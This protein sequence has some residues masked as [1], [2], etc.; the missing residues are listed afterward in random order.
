M[1]RQGRLRGLGEA[2]EVGQDVRAAVTQLVVELAARAELQQV[3]VQPPPGQ[4]ARGVHA[5]LRVAGIEEAVEPGVELGEEVTA[6]LD[7]GAA[8]DQGRR[9]SSFSRR[10][11]ARS[12]AT[13]RRWISWRRVLRRLCSA[14]HERTSGRSAW[15]T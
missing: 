8:G 13:V 10:A 4:E 9:A 2:V 1:D 6:G 3:E 12:R 14:S 7:Q 11:R 15:G 5:G